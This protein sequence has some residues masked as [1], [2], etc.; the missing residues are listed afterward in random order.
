MLYFFQLEVLIWKE[1]DSLSVGGI[2]ITQTIEKAKRLLSED[3][4]A[5]DSLKS[6]FELLLV[7]ISLLLARLGVNSENSS[8]PPS[9][10]P[11]R[12]RGSKRRGK[13]GK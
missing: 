9:Q 1:V 11:N 3:K 7:V 12:K 5:S 8:K 2:N 6:M 13:S 10:D 4:T